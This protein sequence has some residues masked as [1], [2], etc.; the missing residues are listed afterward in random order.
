MV[1]P[2][3]KPIFSWRAKLNAM[4]S[5]Q[6]VAFVERKLTEAGIAKI[7]PPK[8]QLDKAYRIFARSARLK[9][10]G[11][12]DDLSRRLAVAA[13]R[14]AVADNARNSG[15]RGRRAILPSLGDNCSSNII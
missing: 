8:D 3:R 6:F 14:E 15:H 7:V 5:D 9:L 10:I 12:T 4:T 2:E 13:R 1:R 11:R